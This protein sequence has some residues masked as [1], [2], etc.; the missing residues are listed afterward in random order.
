MVVL[1]VLVSIAVYYLSR[2]KTHYQFVSKA[3]LIH[4]KM[5]DDSAPACES[6]SDTDIRS[7]CNL[8]AK[9]TSER[10]RCIYLLQKN[11]TLQTESGISLIIDFYSPGSLLTTDSAQYSR[12][13]ISIRNPEVN[14][15]YNVSRVSS[16]D[17]QVY[18]SSGA[19]TG[20]KRCAGN[21]ANAASGLI[22]LKSMEENKIDAKI[23]I[24]GKALHA[25]RPGA[26][27]YF[28][29]AG[30]YT[31]RASEIDAVNRW[32]DKWNNRGLF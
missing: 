2:P 15:P 32:T 25:S 11:H 8:K 17:V 31:F 6:A 16:G 29:F 5:T 18:Y 22:I 19:A 9:Q 13:T 27:E 1:L 3:V 12:L 24:H 26:E 7:D 23:E 20:G 30:D 10:T 28:V 14:H 21:Y 4:P